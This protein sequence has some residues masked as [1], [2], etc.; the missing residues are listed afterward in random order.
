MEID[1]ATGGRLDEAPFDLNGDGI[2]DEADYVDLDG[3][4]V[5]DV[6]ASG[7]GSRE[8]I[9]ARPGVIADGDIEYKFSSGSTGQ[10]QRTVEN[11]G[12]G[13][14]GRTSWRELTQ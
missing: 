14:T 6:P 13:Y 7:I 12:L 1:A 4:G 10:I 5:N 11:A 3:D 9:I 2:F 8:G